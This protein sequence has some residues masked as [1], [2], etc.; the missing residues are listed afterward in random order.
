MR[1]L[2]KVQ[3]N[4]WSLNRNQTQ[5]CYPGL[6]LSEFDRIM[7]G[8][9]ILVIRLHPAC[10]EDMEGAS[11]DMGSCT[12][13]LLVTLTSGAPHFSETDTT[14]LPFYSSSTRVQSA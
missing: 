8:G 14:C 3:Q 5:V 12:V 11:V 10:G 2:S 7:G 4:M 6:N 9:G 1:M 13:Y